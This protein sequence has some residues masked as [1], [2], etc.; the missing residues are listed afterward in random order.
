MT[1][2]PSASAKLARAALTAT[3]GQARERRFTLVAAAAGFGKTTSIAAAVGGH[4]HVW[5][6]LTAADRDPDVLAETLAPAR[7]GTDD[8]MVIDEVE[9]IAEADSAIALLRD[10]LAGAAHVVLSGRRLPELRLGTAVSRGEVLRVGAADL[11]F[12]PD[13]VAVLLALRVGSVSVDLAAACW[14][15]TR[16]WPAAVCLAADVL[17]RAGDRT[18]HEQ[19]WVA[20]WRDV[21]TEVIDAQPPDV[22]RALAVSSVVGSA[23]AELLTALAVAPPADQFVQRGLFVDGE[24]GAPVKVS[25]VLAAAAVGGLEPAEANAMR[26]GA[27]IWYEEHGRLGDALECLAASG[28]SAE[29]RSYLARCGY[30]LAAAGKAARV[31]EVAH[32][33]GS[34]DQPELDAVL[35][36]ALWLAGDW[37]AAAEAFARAERASGPSLAPAVAWRWGALSV[38][39]GDTQHAESM[40]RGARRN[41]PPGADDAQVLAWL[42]SVLV[43]TGRVDEADEIAVAALG[44][45]TECADEQARASALLV[46]GLLGWILHGD[47]DAGRHD[48]LAAIAA[49]TNA[50]D[51]LQCAR[52]QLN[53]ATRALVD[54]DYAQ[55]IRHADEALTVASVHAIFRARALAHKGEAMLRQGHLDHARVAAA[56]ALDDYTV[57][58]PARVSSAQILLAEIYRQRGDLVSARMYYERVLQAAEKADESH[59]L[60]EGHVGLA[61]VLARDDPAAAAGHVDAAE[62]RATGVDR[63]TALNARAWLALC[64]ADADTAL[65]VARRAETLAREAGDRPAL[66]TALE[67]AAAA[68]TPPDAAG[69]RAAL[70]IWLDIGD[71]IASARAAL[72]IAV[73][74][75]DEPGLVRARRDLAAFGAAAN[76]GVAGVLSNAAR[77][78]ARPSIVTL[79]RFAVTVAGRAVPSGAWQSRKARDLL[80]LLV[81]RAG[82]PMTRDAAAEAL[83]PDAEPDVLS[84]RLSVALSIVRRILDPER[85][86]EADEHI[87]ADKRSIVLR[88]D[89]VQV[90]VVAFLDAAADGARLAARG[91]WAAAEE[92]LRIADDLYAGDFLEGDRYEDWAQECREQARSS[93]LTTARLLARAAARRDDDEGVARQLLRLLER[94]SYD[95]DAWTALIGAQL[96][97]RR[98]GE[99]RHLHEAYSRRMAEL[100]VPPTSLPGLA[101]RLP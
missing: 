36:N 85:R 24:D 54:G 47:A 14:A 11:A 33:V 98:H 75:G 17:A 38:L 29:L 76:L 71:P 66:A 15:A 87:G 43:S 27:A 22:Q 94:D 32:A 78:D 91:D 99:A 81:S 48:H 92:R 2:A 56:D 37:D 41:D 44:L 59:L 3:L 88:P 80:K 79:G 61:L 63:A 31:A 13:E 6:T 97:L 34:A 40:L 89:R 55:T 9:H 50:G 53:L 23:D 12:S 25:P 20:N 26:R 70:A 96:R 74:G 52:I 64:A 49:A 30:R 65:D 82:R 19:A 21:A 35:G 62:A 57:V 95:E 86:G 10:V 1:A 72:A 73:A 90:D 5:I 58:A 67:L 68:Q 42:A 45:A 69:L 39:R 7:A 93:A 101:E 28:E 46:R 84:N 18:Q 16:G 77:A 51:A 60:L 8:V 83:W 100:G 4:D